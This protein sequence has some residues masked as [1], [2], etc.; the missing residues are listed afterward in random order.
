MAPLAPPRLTA[1]LTCA[2]SFF[3]L[4]IGALPASAAVLISVNKSTQQISCLSP[5]TASESPS[6]IG[7]HDLD[8]VPQEENE[9]LLHRMA[10]MS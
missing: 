6:P 9:L 2:L 1:W 3:T 10:R 4:T 5:V 8:R 7:K